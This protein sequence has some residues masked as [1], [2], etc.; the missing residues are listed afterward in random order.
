[1]SRQQG[2]RGSVPDKCLIARESIERHWRFLKF[3]VP[4]HRS[5]LQV[6]EIDRATT[7]VEKL[8]STNLS[9][10]GRSSSATDG[11]SGCG[12]LG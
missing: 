12:W 2:S 10:T 11:H 4:L 8:L 5:R 1:M 6:F 3:P 9:I 7:S